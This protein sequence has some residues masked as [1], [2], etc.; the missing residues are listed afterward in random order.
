MVQLRK[1]QTS[2]RVQ[3]Y[4]S[5][6]LD[7][8]FDLRPTTLYHY[9]LLSK[10]HVFP[11]LGSRKLKSLTSQDVRDTLHAVQQSAGVSPAQ[12]TRVLLNWCFK[13][14][15]NEGLVDRNPVT[16]VPIPKRVHREIRPLSPRE[17]DAIAEAIYPRYRTMVTL[18]AYSGL[19]IGEL[20]GLKVSD[21]DFEK[22]ALR[23]RR[24]S[25][26]PGMGLSE[27]KT[28]SSRRSVALPEFVLDD[29][30]Q[31]IEQYP[32]PDD[33]RVFSTESGGLVHAQALHGVWKKACR[34]AG[35]PDTRFHDLRHTA[36][37]LAIATG[38]H[39]K[40]VQARMGHSNV[41]TTLD[42]YGHLFPGLDVELA[43][44]LNA[45]KPTG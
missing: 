18:A 20:G 5:K 22:K 9:R 10:N 41:S 24:A 6:L 8:A 36:A 34:R 42:V 17:V 43:E 12:N 33:G 29:L 19:R 35:L 37:S 3:D 27:P 2:Y 15:M 23:V 7:S 16:G 31:H 28:A 13:Q 38:A 32:P 45:L 44:G 4:L 1:F 39:V 40:A 11:H 26:K 14:A 30:R 21:I 25:T